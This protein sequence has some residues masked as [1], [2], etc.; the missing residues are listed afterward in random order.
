MTRSDIAARVLAGL[1]S[2]ELRTS[3]AWL[4]RRELAA[5]TTVTLDRTEVEVPWPALLA[6]I[7]LQPAANWGHPCRY[8][9]VARDSGE[10]RTVEAAFP[11]F[12]RGAVD[13]WELIWRGEAV[14]DWAIAG[15]Q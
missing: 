10:I 12:R 7:D 6:F 13:D 4:A 1:T 11:P 3:V 15:R 14:P 9:L 2:G 8:L 5:A